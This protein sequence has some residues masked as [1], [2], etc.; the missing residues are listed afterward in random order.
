MTKVPWDFAQFCKRVIT[1]GRFLILNSRHSKTSRPSATSKTR[2]RSPCFHRSSDL[3]EQRKFRA[4]WVYILASIQIMWMLEWEP[5]PRWILELSSATRSHSKLWTSWMS[6]AR[7][8][9]PLTS[10]MMGRLGS[11]EMMKQALIFRN[12]NVPILVLE[13]VKTLGGLQTWQETASVRYLL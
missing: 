4:V 11:S 13:R 7:S 6:R 5:R 1:L 2:T 12:S 10:I 8:H 3:S 9:C